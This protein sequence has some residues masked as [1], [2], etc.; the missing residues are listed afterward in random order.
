VTVGPGDSVAVPEPGVCEYARE[1]RLQGAEPQFVAHDRMLDCDPASHA[2]VLVNTPDNPTGRTH[3]TGDLRRFVA[4]CRAVGTPL[5]ADEAHLGFTD[6]ASLAG[7]PGTVVVREPTR[8]FGVPGLRFGFA[9]AGGDLGTRP[10]GARPAWTLSVP[11]ADVG[12]H[13]M[14]QTAFVE[15]TRE[16]VAAERARLV[17]ALSTDYDVSDSDAP[18]LLLDVGDRSVASVRDRAREHGIAVRDATTFRG[19]D[20]HLRVAVRRE[21]D[22]DR[23]L[24]ALLTDE[25]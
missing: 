11:S 7:E 17:D 9:V 1:V 2:A 12:A 21:R 3:P 25:R 10:D 22:N 8:L 6:R 4:E 20:S 19:L 18:F 14:R 16:R 5:L 15:R 13:C 24:D 23:L